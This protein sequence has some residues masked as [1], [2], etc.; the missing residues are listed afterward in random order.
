[1]FCTVLNIL[2]QYPLLTLGRPI[3]NYRIAP[4]LFKIACKQK[5][6]LRRVFGPSNLGAGAKSRLH[7]PK[8]VTYH[9]QSQIMNHT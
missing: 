4:L 7:T 1:M 2:A 8:A 6:D 9:E 3:T 5:L